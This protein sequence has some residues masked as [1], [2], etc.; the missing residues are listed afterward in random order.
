M[1]SYGKYD[2]LPFE[3]IKVN[4]F[5]PI[6][7]HFME[8]TRQRVEAIKSLEFPDFQNTI[9]ALEASGKEL[10]RISGCFFNLNS[11]ETSD[12]MQALASE[13]APML[14]RFDSEINLDSELF[15]KVKH[16]YE[17][18]NKQTLTIEGQRLLEKTW[19]GFVR[20]GALLPS[21]KKQ[22]LSNI[23]EA[24]SKI[25]EKYG[26]NLLKHQNSFRYHTAKSEDLAG[27]PNEVVQGAAAKAKDAGEQGF[28]L[29]LDMPTYTAVMTYADNR[30][31]RQHFFTAWN[32]RGFESNAFNNEALCTEISAL[33]ARRAIL[34][35]YSS[36]A[37]FV[38]EE[39]MAQTPAKVLE[40][41]ENL[42]RKSMPAAQL[43]LD[44]VREFALQHGAPPLEK[45]DLNYWSEKLKRARYDFDDEMLKPYFSAEKV[46]QGAF[47][48]AHRLY[49]LRF[50][51]TTEISVYHPE[52]EVY[53]VCE[54]DGTFTALLYVDLFPRSGKRNGAWM[55]DYKGQYIQNGIDHRPH[56]SIVCNFNRA[57]TDTPSLL[58]FNEVTTLFHEFGHAL[59]GML[60]KGKYEHLSGTNVRWDFVELP[61]QIMENWCYEKPC[62]DLFAQHYSTGEKIPAHY[63]EKLK[64]AATFMEGYMT[65]RQLNF[66]FLDMAW[67]HSGKP[68]EFG[69]RE[70][71]KEIIS[72]TELFPITDDICISTAFS[73]IF[74]GGYSAGYYSY[75]WAEVLDADAFESFKENGIFDSATALRFR[76]CVL[77]KGD[78]ESPEVLYERFKGRQADA[79]ALLRRA[80]L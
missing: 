37:E 41:L 62:L 80:G 2:T 72:R 32:R 22:M 36:H 38:L 20:N 73:H 64:R 70:F 57:T 56:V 43:Q 18:G 28:V 66:A 16:V 26:Q 63:I 10:H 59:H 23:D 34:L 69:V 5:L 35:G 24:L 79:G 3:N 30:E 11:A 47:E 14:S 13:I 53:E 42:Y 17:K 78:S 8:I 25:K 12:E 68:E 1:F 27:L 21:D 4:D 52:V 65:L 60:A 71:E 50:N 67:H 7:Q 51:R 77:E 48:T 39:R 9:E 33:I 75:K 58:T 6:I 15:D 76:E 49:G 40:F 45:W 55:T 54:A 31:L 44:E 19:K 29:S 61:S 74:N 46:L